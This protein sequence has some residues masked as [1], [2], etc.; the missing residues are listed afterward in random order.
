[1]SLYKFELDGTSIHLAVQESC[2]GTTIG[3]QMARQSIEKGGRVLWASPELPD[4]TRFSQIFDGIDPV[5]SSRFHA[6]NLVGNFDQALESLISAAKMLPSVDLV[7]LDDYCPKSGKIP[8]D[9][10]KGV[11]KLIEVSKWTTLLISKGG[12]SMD[13]SPLNA[14]A[15]NEINADS[16]WLLTRKKTDNRRLLQM[17]QDSLELVLTEDGYTL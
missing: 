1:L 6:M 13:E 11:N 4:G 15:S 5:S 14:R 10:I 3:L 17:D 7:I 8:N 16:I 9:I 12:E 2:G